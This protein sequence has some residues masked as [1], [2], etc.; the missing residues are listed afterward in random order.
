MIR[1][2]GSDLASFKTLTF[3]PGL[4]ILLADKSEGAND[5]QSRNGAGKTSFIELVHFLFGADA[6][7]DSIFRSDALTAWTFDVSVD[8]AQ[9]TISAARSGAKPSRVFVNG[10]VENWPIPPQFDTRAGLF[11]LSNENWKANL[12]QIWFGLPIS[13]GDEAERFQPSFR[14][15]FSYFVRRQNSGGFQQPMQHS[16]MQQAWDQQ[17]S[18]CYLLGLD[19]SIPGRFQELRAQEKVAQELRKAARSGDL[20]RFFGKAAD[21]RT[22]LTVAEARAVRLRRQLE[23]FEVV[24]EYKALEREAN[25]ITRE[26][27]G[28]NVE[29]VIDGDL[30]QQLRASLVD[31]D[32]PD[33]GD[34]TK[35]YAEAGVVLPDMV[36]RR[37]DEV[38]RFHR[39]I[40]ENRRAHLTA[41]IASAEARIAERDQRTAERDRRRRQIM[42]VLRSGGAL[43]HYTSLREEAGRAEA[44][45]EGLRQ[46]L[47]TAERIESTKAELDIERAN[48]TKA[49]RDDI[50]ERTDII[51]EAILIFESLSESLYEKAGSLTI[52]ETGSGPQFEVHIDGQRSKGITNMQIFCFDLMLTEISLKN[53]RGPGF[54]I[55]DSHLFDGVDERQVAKALQLGAERAEAAGFQYIVTMNSDALPREGFK[56]GFDIR[57]Y[58]M[59]TKLTDA[60]DTGGLFGLRFE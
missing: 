29:N 38:E 5:R 48:L 39:T 33:L 4:N 53:G 2:F 47:D 57:S 20:G 3:K 41:E 13:A 34:V 10:A 26:I 56:T 14:S 31:E 22:K 12:G 18:I 25:E 1:R 28:M 44:E 59:D 21:L 52:A 54:L 37:F 19:W 6:R 46:R 9:E 32:A 24:P 35:L 16:G 17:V 43:E 8:I 23:T 51:R 36:R 30:L 15:L 60:T 40:I 45:V 27:D 55:H 49:L 58:V 42:G 7:K 50:H 11:E